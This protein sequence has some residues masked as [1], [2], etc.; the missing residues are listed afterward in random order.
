MPG[1]FFVQA[2]DRL[3]SLK[4][5]NNR[6]CLGPWET[7]KMLREVKK[8][9][10][11]AVE[12]EDIELIV[13]FQEQL[14]AQRVCEQIR[15]ILD[16]TETDENERSEFE[17]DENVPDSLLSEAKLGKFLHPKNSYQ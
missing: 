10:P 2:H 8:P 15:D 7:G 9:P 14:G 6:A 1:A 5:F 17:S 13:I 16:Q 3:S 11:P 12:D 4:L